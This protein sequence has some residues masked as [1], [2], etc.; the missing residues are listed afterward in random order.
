VGHSRELSEAEIIACFLNPTKEDLE[1]ARCAEAAKEV[2]PE[3]WAAMARDVFGEKTSKGQKLLMPQA[4][5]IQAR[6]IGVRKDGR[7]WLSEDGKYYLTI[8]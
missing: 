1:I 2:K 5:A 4:L 7:V 6:V 8:F 3:W